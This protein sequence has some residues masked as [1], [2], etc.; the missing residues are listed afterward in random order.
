MLTLDDWDSLEYMF[1][2]ARLSADGGVAYEIFR[3]LEI[4][5]GAVAIDMR[6]AAQKAAVGEKEGDGG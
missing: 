4:G 3:G 6:D 2:K 1:Y 5:A